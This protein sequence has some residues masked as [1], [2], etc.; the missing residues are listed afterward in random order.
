MLDTRLNPIS[1][2]DEFMQSPIIELL[3]FKNMQLILSLSKLRNRT[4]SETR[5]V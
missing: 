1:D 5:K 4:V 3:D 2:D